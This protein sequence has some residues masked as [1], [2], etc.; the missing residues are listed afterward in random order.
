MPTP[1]AVSFVLEEIAYLRGRT[2][3]EWKMNCESEKAGSSVVWLSDA[4]T[5]SRA[6]V[7]GVPTLAS[8]VPDRGV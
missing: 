6:S 1:L 4:K 5:G 2:N 3:D 7:I 8:C